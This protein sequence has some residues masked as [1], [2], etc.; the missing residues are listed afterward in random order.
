MTPPDTV[1]LVP[2]R[3]SEGFLE[4]SLDTTPDPPIVVGRA[5]ISRGRETS[6]TERP[7]HAEKTIAALTEEDVLE[8]L[9]TALEPFV[10]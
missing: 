2:E 6:E 8:F 5:R 10:G 3:A 4:I 1:R 9:A 7:V